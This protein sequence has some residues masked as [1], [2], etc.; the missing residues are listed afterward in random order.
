[1][2]AH[3]TLKEQILKYKNLYPVLALTG[4]RQSGKT[5]LLKDLFPNYTYLSLENPDTRQFAETDPNGFFKQCGSHVILDEAQRVPQLFSY[6]QSIVDSTKEMGQFI[7]SGSQNFHLMQNIT[8]SLA[9]R[10]ILFKLLP[11][12]FEELKNIN[13]L[14]KNY[15][16]LIVKGSYPAIYDREIPSKIF[17]SNYIQTYLERD[18]SELLNVKDTR[19][20]K[21]FLSICATRAGQLIN[22]NSI[23]NECGISQPTAK[24]WLSVLESSYIVFLLS[25]YHQNF[26]KRI[27]K[28]PK[29]YF[30][31]TGLLAYLLKISDYNKLKTQ[32]EKGA[33]F[34]NLIIA[35]KTKQNYH[36]YLQQEHWFWRDS[37]GKEVDLII[38]NSDKNQVIE[39]KATETVTTKLFES[40]DYF[41]ALS[42]NFVSKNTL[43]Y[44]GNQNQ[45]RTNYTVK[46]WEDC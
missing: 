22:L 25:P 5:T 42:G 35:E 17:Y 33:L 41:K 12:D 34:E 19:Q 2:V 15:A 7:L 11:F 44:G 9:G 43:I 8:Q 39:I 32:G 38:Q 31:D 26:S 20:F 24:S 10:V 28:T 23:A 37:H 4:P 13:S 16:E 46:G 1:M 45:N 21:T 30:Y 18:I 40:L 3:R 36:Q 27:T 29:L 14:P 6:I